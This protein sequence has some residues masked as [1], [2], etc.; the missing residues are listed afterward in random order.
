MNSIKFIHT[1]KINISFPDDDM[2][3]V[4]SEPKFLA[5]NIVKA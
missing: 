2:I 1:G 3:I 5:K 4:V